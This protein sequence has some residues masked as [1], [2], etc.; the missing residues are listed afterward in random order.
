[1][2]LFMEIR[3]LKYFLAV[4]REQNITVAANY[5]HITQ[6]TLSRQIKELEDELGFALLIR[7]SHN[8]ELTE[9]G[10]LFRKR[11]EEIVSMVDKTEDEFKAMKD[12]ISGDIF[13]GT[14]ES[15]IMKYIAKVFKDLQ[16]EFPNIHY[17][18]VSGNEK[19]VTDLLDKGLLDFC[20]LVQPADISKYNYL[21]LPD[22]DI[23]G[24]VMKKNDSL[25]RKEV[26]TRSDLIKLPLIC[27]RQSIQKMEDKKNEFVEWFGEDFEKLNIVS[28][29]NLP[30]NASILV[31][32]DIGYAITIDKIIDTS[33]NSN[34]CFKP[35]YPKLESK[36]NIVWKKYNV[37]SKPAEK[38]LQ[39]F[40]ITF[41]ED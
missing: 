29:F 4:A 16:N 27:S 33:I 41:K 14:A 37:F 30:Y 40:Q 5:L 20:V 38:L 39:K 22:K 15:H 34:L 7:K 13:I 23:W 26:I 36:L 12:N 35:L 21:N 31:N 11:A 2:R 32:A 24:I 28:T 18:L 6:P 8:V 1:M 10:M 9:E 19:D 3:V 17:H 25:A